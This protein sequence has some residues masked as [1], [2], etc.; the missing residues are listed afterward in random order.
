[1]LFE[2]ILALQII[3]FIFIILGIFPYQRSADLEGNQN[4][5]PFFNKLIFIF[6][7]GIL[8]WILSLF[9]VSYDYNYCY[10]NQTT[11]D[12]ITNSTLSTA[13]CGSYAIQSVDLSYLNMGMGVLSIVLFIVVILMTIISRKD[14]LMKDD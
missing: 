3:A 2:I 1:M 6:I 12:F 10:I 11:S 9:T 4:K 7:G 13:T 5:P 14:D 8:F